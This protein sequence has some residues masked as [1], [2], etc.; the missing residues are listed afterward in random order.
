[1]GTLLAT[2]VGSGTI[3]GGGNSLAYNYGY[4]WYPVVIPFIVFCIIYMCVYKQIRKSNCFTVP[5]IL[6]QKYGAET[7]IL[8]S[9]INL[10]G[11]AGI[12]A[13]QYKDLDTF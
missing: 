6:Q 8:G 1:M 7:R 4:C 12:I 13:S 9:V 11:M 10:F 5:Q 2:S 3:T